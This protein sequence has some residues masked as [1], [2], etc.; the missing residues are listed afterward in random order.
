M[1]LRTHTISVSRISY[2]GTF[3]LLSAVFG[4]LIVGNIS[5]THAESVAEATES[6]ESEAISDTHFVTFHEN[7]NS[8]TIKTDARTVEEALSRAKIDIADADQIDPARTEKIDSNN[9]HINIYRARPVI[10]SDGITKKYIMS[11]SY[12]KETVAK[13][14]GFSIYDGDKIELKQDIKNVLEAGMTETYEIKRKG[15]ATITVEEEIPYTE[16]VEQDSSLAA[17]QKK[18]KQ[19]GELGIRK[20]T[21]KVKFKDGV[22]VERVKVS[23][24]V[25]KEPVEKIT[26]VGS[27]VADFTANPDRA[28]CESWMRAAGIAESD[29]ETA[30]WIIFK[31]SKCRYNATNA[32]S[33]AYGIP[34]SLPGR[35]M[36]SAGAD[37]ETNPVTQI[38][39][40]ISY[41]NNRYGGWDGAKAWWLSHNWY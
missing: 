39:W 21:Y 26:V 29:M 27:K 15:G 40:M 17:G 30:Y 5:R 23:E 12:D 22:E 28:T 11:A 38:K 34:Q 16:K 41:V 3:A 9:Y 2:I 33:G 32:S 37:W 24:E 31:E 10:V 19:I 35:K 1:K 36:A 7:G 14:A 4:F 13:Q 6:E 18:E 8:L 25:V 20:T